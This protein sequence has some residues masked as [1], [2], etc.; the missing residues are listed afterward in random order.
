MSRLHQGAGLLKLQID[1]Y[2]DNRARFPIEELAT[3]AGKWVAF[4]PDGLRILDSC[5]SLVE[6]NKRLAM[7][8]QDTEAVVFERVP[9]SDM[10]FSESELS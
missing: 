8:G 4:S 6:L 1:S 10:I 7:A 9:T 5:E 2:I 3:Y